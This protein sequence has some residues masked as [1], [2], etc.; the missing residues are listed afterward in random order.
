MAITKTN[1]K[2]EAY[3]SYK[4]KIKIFFIFTA[5][6]NDFYKNLKLQLY[7]ELKKFKNLLFFIFFFSIISKKLDR[8]GKTT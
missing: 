3:H 7:V 1:S 6:Y 5:A 4:T 2:K 8:T